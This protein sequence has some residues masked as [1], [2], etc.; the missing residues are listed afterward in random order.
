[1]TAMT[2]DTVGL[3]DCAVK[4]RRRISGLA[5]IRRASAALLIPFARRTESSVCNQLVRRVDLGRD[6]PRVGGERRI[7]H[8]TFDILVERS[9]QSGSRGRLRTSSHEP[10]IVIE[11]LRCRGAQVSSATARGRDEFGL[12]RR[13]RATSESRSL[14]MHGYFTHWPDSQRKVEGQSARV[15]HCL[16]P[17]PTDSVDGGANVGVPKESTA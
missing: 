17:G 6:A 9:T 5:P 1:V 2:V 4:R 13:A 11:K 14:R 10:T 7:F 8:S 15:Q 12:R 3:G 16:C